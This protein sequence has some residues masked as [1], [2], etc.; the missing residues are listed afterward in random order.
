MTSVTNCEA[1]NIDG[2][3]LKNVNHCI[4]EVAKNS[5]IS[6]ITSTEA[7][8]MSENIPFAVSDKNDESLIEPKNNGLFAEIEV[9]I[10]FIES[11]SPT[12]L[13]YLRMNH[14]TFALRK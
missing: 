6:M 14:F 7:E 13:N 8:N 3:D 11:I 9:I 1:S 4:M 2:E 12:C 5:A 10:E